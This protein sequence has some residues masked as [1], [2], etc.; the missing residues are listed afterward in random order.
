MK[1]ISCGIILATSEGWLICHSTGNKHWDFPKGIAEEGEPHFAA[2]IREL[3]EETGYELDPQKAVVIK[4]LGQHPYRTGE[5]DVRL[6]Y[7]YMPGKIDT[8]LLKCTSMVECVGKRGAYKFPEM[9]EFEFK[10]PD[11]AMPIL[12]KRMREWVDSYVPEDLKDIVVLYKIS[13]M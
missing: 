5:K 13:R 3:K 7:V 9:D 1:P 4:D 12:S 10:R 8:T 2:A 11:E 6:F